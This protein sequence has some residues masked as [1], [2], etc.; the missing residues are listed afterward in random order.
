MSNSQFGNNLL[1]LLSE[2]KSLKW[3]VFKK[4]IEALLRQNKTEAH[5]KQDSQASHSKILK[6]S[7][8]QAYEVWRLARDLSAMAYL[9]MGGKTGETV[10]KIAP[11]MLAELPFWKPVFLLT[12]ARSPELLETVKESVK[13]YSKI[14]IEI[15]TD[16]RRPE[17]ALIKPESRSILRGWLNDTRFQRNSLS[18]YMKIS[19]R[20]PAWDILEFA[21]SLKSYQ[22]SLDTEWFGGSPAHIKEIF[23]INPL[24][25]KPFDA[26]NNSLKHDFVSC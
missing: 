18:D 26:D 10:V 8:K 16:N 6:N 3:T 2:K 4:H 13:K 12:G 19:P 5:D 17:T 23:D 1:Y 20:P 22:G 15:K 11:P 9:D 7:K 21:G 14:E 24:K 25:F